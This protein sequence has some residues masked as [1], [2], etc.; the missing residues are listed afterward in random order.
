MNSIDLK[1]MACEARHGESDDRE[2]IVAWNQFDPSYEGGSAASD[3]IAAQ[4]RLA[5]PVAIH[6]DD[7]TGE[8]HWRL[9]DRIRT[10]ALEPERG[11]DRLHLDW[12]SSRDEHHEVTLEELYRAVANTWGGTGSRRD[13]NAMQ[14]DACT[15][16]LD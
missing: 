8:F 1:D 13:V 3:L 15:R 14:R 16:L 10:T 6:V 2:L 12:D 9:I 7:P 4:T 5:M 11:I